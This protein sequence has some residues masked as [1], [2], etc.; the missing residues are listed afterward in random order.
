[1]GHRVVTVSSRALGPRRHV[2]VVIYDTLPE[3]QAA[4]QAYNGN[5]QTGAAGLTQAWT[6]SRGRTGGVIVRLA[7]GY[8]G[9]RVVSHEIHHAATAIYGSMVG[10]RISRQA[11]LNHY[12]EPFA[13]LY[14]DLLGRLVDRLY[15]LGYYG[16][17]T[18]A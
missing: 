10:D 11:H 4:G 9:T 2:R 1:M 18:D 15:E 5:D 17:G 6:D 3:L 7:R 12:N 14:S 13:H 16:G 8:L